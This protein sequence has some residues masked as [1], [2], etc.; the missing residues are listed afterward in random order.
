MASKG[1]DPYFRKGG[2]KMDAR[3]NLSIVALVAGIAA[4]SC[5]FGCTPPNPVN[6]LRWDHVDEAGT[7]A[8]LW[9]QL[10]LTESIENWKE[11]FVWD[12]QGHDNWQDYANKVWADNYVAINRFSVDVEGLDRF[13]AYHYRAYVEDAET[14]S[15]ARVGADLDFIPGGPRVGAVPA[16]NVDTASADLNG[17]LLHMGGAATVDVLFEYGEDP[18]SLDME[19]G[20]QTLTELG[21]FS[22]TLDDLESCTKVHFRAVAV[23]DADT[24]QGQI[25]QVTPGEPNV[26]TGFPSDLGADTAT[27]RG[28]LGHL[29][30][31]PD[32]AVW[33]EY[34]DDSPGNLNQSTPP[35]AM[36]APGDFSAVIGDL[37]PSTMYWYRAVADNG[38]CEAEGIVVD[39]TTPAGTP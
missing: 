6:T 23:N 19:A 10:I 31:M 21:E 26:A 32:A 24:H 14:G 4:I 28:R 17:E 37:K 15:I 25:S 20:H 3:K 18:G 5:L 27:L 7:A 2:K 30:G 35:Q 9:G 29:A 39:F 22:T 11:G 8:R 33:F 36:D 12:T 16:S 34:S 1:L 38:L 13:T